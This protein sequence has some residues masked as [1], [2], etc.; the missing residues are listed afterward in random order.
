MST[1]HIQLVSKG[2]RGVISNISKKVFP[3]LNKI[4]R[5][6]LI[7]IKKIINCLKYYFVIQGIS[8]GLRHTV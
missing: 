3:L 2:K 4:W 8:K 5:L 1:S 7:K 6:I